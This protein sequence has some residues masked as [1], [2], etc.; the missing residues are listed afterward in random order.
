MQRQQTYNI[1]KLRRRIPEDRAEIF[2]KYTPWQEDLEG[3]VRTAHELHE[4][5]SG[6]PALRTVWDNPKNRNARILTEVVTCSSAT[7]AL[8]ALIERL[9]WNQLEKLPEGGEQFGFASFVHPEGLPPA[10]YF[11]QGNL[12]ITIAS[13]SRE[14]VPVIPLASRITRRLAERPEVE[15][16]SLEIKPD[17]SHAKVG[18]PVLINYDL[19]WQMGEYGFVK[20]FSSQGIIHIEDDRL[21]ALGT[22]P[23]R[24]S[25]EA[26][27][28][29]PNRQTYRGKMEISIE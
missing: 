25:V 2:L 5:A 17:K 8:E 15:P 26:F 20:L 23:G 13:Y 12:C 7:E 3:W 28:M 4:E 22:R 14:L 19:P 11:V 1:D 9:N 18:E 27:A 24:I 10:V 21:V 6:Q 16:V 29:E